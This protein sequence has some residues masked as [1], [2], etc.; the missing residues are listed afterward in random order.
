MNFTD[1]CPLGA[2][3][4]HVDRKADSWI[5]MMKLIGTSCYCEYA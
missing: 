4:I 3:L 5:D 2:V 1:R